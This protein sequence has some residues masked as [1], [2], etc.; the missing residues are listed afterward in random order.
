MEI[1]VTVV[2]MAPKIFDKESNLEKMKHFIK[3]IHADDPENDLIIFPELITTGYECGEEFYELAEPF[4]DSHTISFLAKLAK[5]YDTHIIFGFA[6]EDSDMKGVLYNSAALIDN[7][8]TPVDVY[9]KVHLFG[10][11]KQVFRPGCEYPLF[12][13]EIGNIGIFICWDALFPEVARIYA[14]KGADLLAVCS[15]WESPYAKEWDFI[16]SARAFDNTLHLAASNRIGKDNTLSFFGHSRILN[17]LGNVI[18]ELGQGVESYA[19]AKIDYN[20]IK[21]TRKQ[22]W[23]QL[24]DRRPDTYSILAHEYK[25]NVSEH[26]K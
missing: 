3:Q 22:C 16:T 15:S 25:A 26:K 9:R 23:T 12:R 10:T 18:A 5:H 8:G 13:L 1:N 14:L 21:N 7:K 17:P 11:E 4:P 2:Q 6:E 19:T 20:E 24:A